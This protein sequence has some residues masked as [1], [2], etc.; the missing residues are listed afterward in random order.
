VI[1]LAQ[2]MHHLSLAARPDE[3]SS[4]HQYRERYGLAD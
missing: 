2:L 1:T 3:L 4:L